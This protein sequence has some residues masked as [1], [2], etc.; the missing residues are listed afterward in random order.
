[1][2]VKVTG[3]DLSMTG[4][5]VC[6]TVE[7][8]ACWHVVKTKKVKDLRLPEIKVRIREY[9]TGSDLVLIEMLP[10]SMK[11][12][13]ITGMVQGIARD[14]LLELGVR[15]ADLGPS[16]LKKYATGKGN[17]SK[18]EMALAALKR[19][20]HEFSDDNACDAWWLWVA[21]NEYLGAPVLSLP[22]I[23]RD[24]LANIEMKG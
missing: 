19:G 16:A 7:G 15:Y 17:A 12:A 23:Q 1:V 13:G 6:H 24:Q 21:A 14:L 2:S 3:L 8:V 11:G 20:N 5:G 22:Q 4:T 9:V 18:T 10:P